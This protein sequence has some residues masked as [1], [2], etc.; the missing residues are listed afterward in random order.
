MTFLTHG[1]RLIVSLVAGFVAALL[2][3]RIIH[4]HVF[5]PLLLIGLCTVAGWFLLPRLFPAL[6]SQSTSRTE[7]SGPITLQ[8]NGRPFEATHHTKNV[9]LNATTGQVWFRDTNGK[10]WLLDRLDIRSWNLDWKDASNAYGKITHHDHYLVLTTND[11]DHPMHKISMGGHSKHE[12][13][14]EW[15]A[16]LTA[17]LKL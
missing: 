1:T 6:K 2:F 5:P 14:K 10:E 9:A 17:M 11:L 8:V 4:L 7:R 12:Q 16:R 15:H 13:A 3:Y